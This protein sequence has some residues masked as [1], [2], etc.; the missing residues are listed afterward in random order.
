MNHCVKVILLYLASFS[1]VGRG[2]VQLP[3]HTLRDQA[4]TDHCWAYSMSHALEARALVR[5]GVEFV[6]DIER[7]AKYWVDYER[8]W[9]I[10]KTKNTSIYL[11]T[12]EGGW[13]V[14]FFNAL[15]K[16]GR[17][18]MRSE[19]KAPQILYPVL[20]P[21]DQRLPFFP[22]AKPHVPDP[23][24][25]TIEAV[26][27]DLEEGFDSDEEAHAFIVDYLDK[28]YGKPLS[29]TTWLGAKTPLKLT[30]KAVLGHDFND[31]NSVDQFIL[32]KPVKHVNDPEQWVKYL[33]DRFWGVRVPEG[34]VLSLIRLSLDRKFP[35]TF[36]NVYH[37]MT[38]VGYEKVDENYHYAVADSV[39]GKITWYE[40]QSLAYNLN[41][42]SFFAPA[43]ED[44]LPPRSKTIAPSDIRWDVID[45]TLIPP[46]S[47]R[48]HF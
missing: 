22:V 2:A 5:D 32:V 42:T 21:Y 37:A 27:R 35:V 34:K 47:L 10:Y 38:I 46:G 26:R 18:I 17:T 15:L 36:D 44:Q 28:R 4:S 39:P 45:N 48:H 23:T 16:H 14:E 40:E 41:L 8:M 20:A 29:E 7:D 11:G 24:L 19:M 43:I 13:Q 6:F 33:G 1:V 12:Y 31:I 9:A 30:G 3:L 25:Q